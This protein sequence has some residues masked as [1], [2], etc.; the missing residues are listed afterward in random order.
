MEPVQKCCFSIVRFKSVIIDHTRSLI[1]VVKFNLIYF[2]SFNTLVNTKLWTHS[3]LTSAAVCVVYN[4]PHH[5][6]DVV[7]T[8][9]CGAS[10]LL[11]LLKYLVKHF[12]SLG[13]SMKDLER[14]SRFSFVQ[15]LPI[16]LINLNSIHKSL[17]QWASRSICLEIWC[18]KRSLAPRGRLQNHICRFDG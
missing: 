10:A 16:S 17:I 13:S 3:L 6:T 11:G 5:L 9:C 7:A 1:K 8:A 12:L 4:G 18:I 14:S 2:R 15:F